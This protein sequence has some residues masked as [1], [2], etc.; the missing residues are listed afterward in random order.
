MACPAT[1]STNGS[2][3]RLRSR[4]S[5]LL[6]TV[7]FT[8]RASAASAA[9]SA[10][11]LGIAELVADHQHIDVARCFV[12]GSSQR[13]VD[14][15][16]HDLA[17]KRLQHTPDRFHGADSLQH[18]TVELR[19]DRRLPIRLVQLLVSLLHDRNDPD[20]REALELAMHGAGPAPCEA[21]QLPAVK[22]PVGLAEQQAQ[23]RLLH[24]REE[25]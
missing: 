1:R 25:R 21:D 7:G 22:A 13:A 18:Q 12:S 2:L 4:H 24:G 3:F 19:E 5:S 11:D 16:G 15:R 9:S 17:R 6:I 20:S 10:I 23:Q 8:A 14:E